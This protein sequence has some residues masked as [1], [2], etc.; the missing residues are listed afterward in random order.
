MTLKNTIAANHSPANKY[1]LSVAGLPKFTF[2]KVDGIEQ[3]VKKVTMPDRTAASGGQSDPFDVKATLPL[4]HTAEVAAIEAWFK[5]GKDPVQAGYKKTGTM[6][7]KAIDDTIVKSYSL[8]GMW[9]SK[10]K[11]PDVEM[12][13]DGE[14]AL[15]EV[16]FSVDD[17]DV[18]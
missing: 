18:L 5:A 14:A 11:M 15:V 9:V 2:T 10:L 12:S 16:T 8:E 3:E 17:Y 6:I 7:Y 1:D 4:H 13:N